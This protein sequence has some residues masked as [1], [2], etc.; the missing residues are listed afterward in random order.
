MNT[1]SIPEDR[2]IG[3][4]ERELAREFMRYILVPESENSPDLKFVDDWREKAESFIVNAMSSHDQDT[5]TALLAILV[6]A[7]KATQ[8]RNPVKARTTSR[9]APTYSGSFPRRKR[10]QALGS[11]TLSDLIR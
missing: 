10:G 5:I 4:A 3:E 9:S 6:N 11:F 8:L 1:A 7:S 2:P